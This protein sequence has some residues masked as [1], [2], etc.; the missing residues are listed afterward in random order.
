MKN[1]HAQ[2]SMDY[3]RALAKCLQGGST[4]T[5][6]RALGRRA[7]AEGLE[8]LELARIHEQAL[9]SVVD[10]GASPESFRPIIKK[11]SKFFALVITPIEETHR[12]A[13]EAA[14]R[15]D[16]LNASL[17]RRTSE[18]A[19]SRQRLKAE[20]ARRVSSER[21]LRESERHYGRALAESTRLQKHLRH[22]SRQVLTAQE[23][24]RKKISRELHDQIANTLTGVN[25]Q[26]AD[27]KRETAGL[28]EFLRKKIAA[29]QEMVQ[30]SVE[31]IHRFARELRPTTLDDLGLIPALHSFA[32]AFSKQHGLRIDLAVSA[33]IEELEMGKR[34]VL[35]RVTQEALTNVAKH[36]R[37]THVEVR[38]RRGRGAVTLCIADNG[39]S[40]RVDPFAYRQNSKRLG[41][42]GM[43][44]RVEMV[45]GLFTI[46][47]RPGKG[48]SVH[49]TI[50]AL[51]PSQNGPPAPK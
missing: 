27:L 32:K 20:A 34:T 33:S 12:G 38:I 36:A 22:H 26:L 47:S 16:R 5:P 45:G 30:D 51:H 28:D 7:V 48:T 13:R 6:V 19:A 2:F 18:L 44:E 24:E 41:L 43:R 14:I 39:K 25:A 1:N 4:A 10:S 37:A 23:E 8:M 49:A 15:L 46:E 31:I 40:F 21:A 50:P 35:Y 9:R 17:L 42:M 11:A 29:T 3:R